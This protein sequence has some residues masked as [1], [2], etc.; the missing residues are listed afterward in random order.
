MGFNKF[1]MSWTQHYNIY[2]LVLQIIYCTHYCSSSLI[3]HTLGY[4]WFLKNLCVSMVFPSRCYIV[5]IMPYAT[6]A[7]YLLSLN[8]IYLMFLHIFLWLDSSFLFI[9][10]YI[11]IYEWPHFVYPFFYWRTWWLLEFLAVV[12]KLA[13]STYVQ[14]FCVYKFWAHLNKYQRLCLLNHVACLA[15]FEM[16]KLSSKVTIAFIPISKEW[17]F[18]FLHI[19]DRCWNCQCSE[20]QPNIVFAFLC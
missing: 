5:G 16:A 6:F 1:L 14:D 15:L 3:P 8:T 12:N 17:E 10:E 4:L 13:I 20:I 2:R 9:G 19:L 7:Y 18:L 11:P